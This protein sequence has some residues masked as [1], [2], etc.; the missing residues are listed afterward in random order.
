ML[1]KKSLSLDD[2]KFLVEA[3]CKASME[4]EGSFP[5]SVA[6]VD[7]STYL[8]SMARMDGA[9]LFSAQGAFDKARSSAEGG[10]ST[11]FFEEP[12]N[13]GRFSMLKLP[14]TPIEGGEPVMIDG[15][16]VGAVGVG[17]APPHLDAAFAKAAIHA[18]VK[19]QESINEDC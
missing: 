13:N 16:C 5:V 11:T 12:L 8:Q 14:H 10:H 9:P 19:Q 2:A 4:H 3:V 7:S 17:G 15:I 18:F 6:V 1:E